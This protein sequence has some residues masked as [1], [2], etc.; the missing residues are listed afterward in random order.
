MIVVARN[1]ASIVVLYLTILTV[2]VPDTL[3]PTVFLGRA[4]DLE[5]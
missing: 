5:T 1:V 3:S 2:D 4:L